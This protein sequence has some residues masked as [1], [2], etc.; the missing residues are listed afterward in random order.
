MENLF[1]EI[2]LLGSEIP[3]LKEKRTAGRN[4]FLSQGIPTAKTEAWKYTKP[5]RFFADG[6]SYNPKGETAGKGG[7]ISLPFTD[8]C[9]CFENGVFNPFASNLPQGIEILPLIEALM[10]KSSVREKTGKLADINKHP[11]AALNQAYLNEGV[12]INIDSNVN[13]TKPISI[14]YHISEDHSN[15]LYNLRNVIVVGESASVELCEYF[16]Y[17]GD[18]KSV[19]L[20]NIV[21]EIYI[22]ENAKLNHY[23]DFR[24]I[25]Q[26]RLQLTSL[27]R[28]S[29]QSAA[30]LS[31]FP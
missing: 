29:N 17:D 24:F 2:E 28:Q 30:F 4:A 22:A 16:C 15:S 12:F 21:N 8:Y 5:N 3:W 20:T 25:L 31:G 1:K 18:V 13:I 27:F 14:I 19:Y 10:L 11:F 9:I 23:K 7:K 26:R 6:F